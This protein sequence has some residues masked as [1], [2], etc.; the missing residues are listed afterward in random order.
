M[1][2]S[3]RD[4][5]LSA[6]RTITHLEIDSTLCQQLLER[7][8]CYP[9]SITH[10][11]SSSR[12]HLRSNEARLCVRMMSANLPVQNAKSIRDLRFD[13]FRLCAAKK[14]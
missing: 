10:P 4:K 2:S 12:V 6:P 5:E 9:L 11:A 3:H 13:V 14:R 1:T 7:I 8:S